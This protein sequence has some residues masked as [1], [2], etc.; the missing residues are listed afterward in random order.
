MSRRS[1]FPLLAVMCGL[2]VSAGSARAGFSTLS[3]SVTVD[4]SAG[5]ATFTLDF[6]H[7][8]D[9][10]TLNSQGLQADT[11]EYQIAADP[12]GANP[13][14]FSNLTTIVWG[15]DIHSSNA[16]TV[17]N[18]SPPD[19]SDPH[20]G[21]WGSVR[22]SVPFSVTGD[23]LTFTAP[24]QLLGASDGKVAYLGFTQHYNAE[25]ASATGQS[26]PLPAAVGIGMLMLGIGIVR[27]LRKSM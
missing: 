19:L 18:A 22:G 1:F 27:S 20:S 13:L 3:Q 26:V 16:I 7:A 10:A 21:G 6:G 12:K 4:H 5:D 11:F 2:L 9:F 15:N 17:R 14:G 8:P 25:Q 23:K 24:L